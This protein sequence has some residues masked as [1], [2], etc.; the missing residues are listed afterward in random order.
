MEWLEEQ[1]D[2]AESVAA[3]EQRHADTKQRKKQAY[4]LNAEKAARYRA[5]SHYYHLALLQ[6][7]GWR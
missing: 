2:I 6:L 7:E 4:K 5:A 1:I 3:L